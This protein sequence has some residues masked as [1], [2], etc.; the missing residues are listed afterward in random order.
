MLDAVAA[1]TV[2]DLAIYP[3]SPIGLDIPTGLLAEF[4]QTKN[5]LRDLATLT[6]GTS[7]I[8]RNDTAQAF[9]RAA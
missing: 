6:G 5:Q 1:A 4:L 8:A 2:A 9:T 3:L 7:L